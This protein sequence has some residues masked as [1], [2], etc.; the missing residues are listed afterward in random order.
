LLAGKAPSTVTND[1]HVTLPDIEQQV[2]G[3]QARELEAQRAGKPVFPTNQGL[4]TGP[5]GTE[6]NPVKVPSAFSSRIVGC[7]GGS[8]DHSH[9]LLWHEVREGETTVCMACGQFFTLERIAVDD[10]HHDDHGHH[11][12]RHE[13]K[14]TH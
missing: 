14:A 7:T 8:G 2:R 4:L 11:D 12:A 6:A 3:L 5:F 1:D 10:G 9:E 13:A